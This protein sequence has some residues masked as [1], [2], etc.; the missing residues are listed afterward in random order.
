MKNIHKLSY[1]FDIYF[2]QIFILL[3]DYINKLAKSITLLLVYDVLPHKPLTKHLIN[4]AEFYI[5]NY[6]LLLF[7]LLY[8]RII[9]QMTTNL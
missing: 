5:T 7:S 4:H 2:L 9:I 1:L 3:M 8:T 6:L